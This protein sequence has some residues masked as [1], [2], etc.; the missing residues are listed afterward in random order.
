MDIA[1]G[2]I[3]KHAAYYRGFLA[4]DRSAAPVAAVLVTGIAVWLLFYLVSLV[5]PAPGLTASKARN[6][7]SAA[8]QPAVEATQHAVAR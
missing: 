5:G 7:A 3:E 8:S 1:M 6:G 2:N 4:D